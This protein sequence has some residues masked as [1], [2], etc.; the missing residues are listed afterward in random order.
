MFSTNELSFSSSCV[1][2]KLESLVARIRHASCKSRARDCIGIR[3]I[4]M[5]TWALNEI[6]FCMWTAA[7]GTPT[8]ESSA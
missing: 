8:W 1:H 4:L 3:M 5:Q 2:G 6:E 7:R